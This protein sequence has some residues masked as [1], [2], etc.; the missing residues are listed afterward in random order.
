MF[1]SNIKDMWS[2]DAQYNLRFLFL[3]DRSVV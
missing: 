1:M 2:A 3:D